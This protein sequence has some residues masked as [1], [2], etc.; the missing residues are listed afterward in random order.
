MPFQY[1]CIDYRLQFVETGCG[2]EHVGVHGQRAFDPVAAEIERK[3]AERH[4]VRPCLRGPR[5][6]QA[7]GESKQGHD[8]AAEEGTD[9]GMLRQGHSN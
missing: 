8:Q 6:W 5:A 1:T 7:R 2:N 9:E 3:L 4:V